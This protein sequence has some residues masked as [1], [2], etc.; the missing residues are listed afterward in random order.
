MSVGKRILKIIIIILI[1]LLIAVAA[2]LGVLSVLE[3]KPDDVEQVDV[4]LAVGGQA[5]IPDEEEPEGE[6]AEADA[7][8]VFLNFVSDVKSQFLSAG[9]G[10]TDNE[11]T[12]DS[13]EYGSKVTDSIMKNPEEL[14][15]EQEL[16][17][18]TWNTGY[19]A[20]GDNASFFM[21]GGDDVYTA[22]EERVQ[23][24]IRTIA[25][26]LLDLDPDL[27]LLQEVDRDS[28]R[29]YH[30][31]ERELLVEGIAGKFDT[32]FANNF[33]T[34]YIPYPIPPIGSVDSGLYT[35]S[36]YT[37]ESAERISLP[38]PFKWPVRIVN[39]KRCLLVN[40]LPIEG[41]DKELVLIN[42]HLEAYDSGEG[43]IAQ[44][45][46]LLS[47]INEEREREIT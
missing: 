47:V 19:G 14:G 13:D 15:A 27:I 8:G 9:D 31:D 39:L 11:T 42:L 46:Q 21:D 29:S 16:K 1:I 43:K 18:I 45:K 12:E 34:A 23:A 7:N 41:S 38:C 36:K 2:L 26:A 3:Y 5:E 28:D 35:L 6:D 40:R 30:I 25:A 22:D 33:K 44:T 17:I 4:V 10:D 37:I 20:L 32:T 24:N